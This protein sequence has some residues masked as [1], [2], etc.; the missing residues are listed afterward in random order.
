MW[1]IPGPFVQ[2]STGHDN[3]APLFITCGITPVN[4]A[5]ECRVH[6]PAI[7]GINASALSRDVIALHDSRARAAMVREDIQ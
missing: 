3:G 6:A 4:R 5:H 2:A 7:V 1:R